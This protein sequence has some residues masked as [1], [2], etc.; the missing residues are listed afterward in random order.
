[1]EDKFPYKQHQKTTT[2]ESDKKIESLDL[3]DIL[4][5]SGV[6]SNSF[7][8]YHLNAE[9][10]LALGKL[11]LEN[12]VS[13]IP[14]DHSEFFKKVDSISVPSQKSTH[15]LNLLSRGKLI[16]L[17]T[18][19]RGSSSINQ[20]T[21]SSQL[22][23]G[24]ILHLQS[25]QSQIFTELTEQITMASEDKSL[26]SEQELSS[27][28]DDDDRDQQEANLMESNVQQVGLE[29][30]ESMEQLP[31]GV[32][33]Q[34]GRSPSNKDISHLY[35]SNSHPPDISISS[36]EKQK[37]KKHVTIQ[38]VATDILQKP[39]PK[40]SIGETS[41]STAPAMVEKVD[42]T[43]KDITLTGF[44]SLASMISDLH[45]GQSKMLL[46][47]GTLANKLDS[48]E[49]RMSEMDLSLSILKGAIGTMDADVKNL[50]QKQPS[51]LMTTSAPVTIIPES[52][53]QLTLP[54]EGSSSTE[55]QREIEKAKQHY[56]EYLAGLK[57][58]HLDE[59]TF[60]QAHLMGGL[61]AYFAK[62]YPGRNGVEYQLE[63]TQLGDAKGEHFL[64][65]DRALMRLRSSLHKPVYLPVDPTVPLY[66]G[67]T[68]SDSVEAPTQP[69][70]VASQ[71]IDPKSLYTHIRAIYK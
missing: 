29:G 2:S 59:Q 47:M 52:S 49:T 23:T 24:D 48:L 1:M 43:L 63:L 21:S 54:T 5:I 32:T 12:S 67:I 57:M 60:I 45:E 13:G 39:I 51:P 46:L 58:K 70:G 7:G 20:P 68:R 33:Q 34:T 56:K 44:G 26:L 62:T 50:L 53:Q 69:T 38:R 11:G 40:L 3:E 6:S 17:D 55:D 30:E 41:K 71:S 16:T 35:S 36:N 61:K 25:S 66:P 65:I 22:T 64:A 31:V 9:R 18:Q 14:S 27:S 28:G 19:H 37:P 42:D 15:N 8:F 10:N 4:R